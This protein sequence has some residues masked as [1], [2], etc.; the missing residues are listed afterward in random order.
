[1]CDFFNKGVKRLNEIDWG[2]MG[3]GG[4]PSHMALV[5]EYVRRASLLITTYS[6]KTPYPFFNAAKAFGLNEEIDIL[7]HC[8]HLKSVNNS[9][10]KGICRAY[11]EWANLA[12]TGEYAANQ[13]CDLYDPLIKLF[14]RGGTIK[15]DHGDIIA[16]GYALPLSNAD[17]MSKQTPI[18]TSEEGLEIWEQRK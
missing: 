1:M 16:G 18:D 17:Y 7:E 8:P 11:L 6:L 3:G 12:D 10:V 9:F 13:F 5:K 14:E 4:T 2:L 15:R